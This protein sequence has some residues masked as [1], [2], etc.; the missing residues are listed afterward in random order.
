MMHVI[1]EELRMHKFNQIHS[2]KPKLGN[3]TFF[4]PEIA[5][6]QQAERISSCIPLPH[7]NYD[8]VFTLA[9]DQPYT[10]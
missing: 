9:H 3:L 6:V 1:F 4:P 2:L 5:E 8:T 10:D 7:S